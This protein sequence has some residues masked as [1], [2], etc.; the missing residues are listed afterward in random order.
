MRSRKKIVTT[1]I[2]SIA[3]L[4]SCTSTTIINGL[5]ETHTATEGIQGVDVKKYFNYQYFRPSSIQKLEQ[6][7]VNL[8]LPRDEAQNLK[9]LLG[10]LKKIMSK[11]KFILKINNSNTFS[12]ELIELVYKF[13]LPITIEWTD[14]NQNNIPQN[15]ISEIPSGFCSSIY[16]DALQAIN[17][18][19]SASSNSTMIV[20]TKPYGDVQKLFTT[21]FPEI[22][23]ILFNE[24]D[25][26]KFA[27]QALEISQ[28]HNRFKKITNLNPNQ[29]LEFASR[30]RD[31]I[32][33]IFLLLEPDQYKSVLPAF[34][35]HG[36]EKFQYIN[37]IS[38]LESLN[39]VKQL[40][41]FE[42]SLVPISIY[43]SKGIE[44]KEIVSL[45]QVIQKSMLN[46]WLLIE[47]MKQ[48]GIRSADIIGMTGTLEFERNNC[49]KR[50]LPIQRIN[51]TW[52]TS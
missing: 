21:Q 29:K 30:P 45:D 36:G 4:A 20:Y 11:E 48:A 33:K 31:D 5:D 27:S 52:V 47:I 16:Q 42:N 34:R 3:I 12:L 44:N 40:L 49:T 10:N 41:D 37:F 25:A 39:N 26:Q 2:T 38:A 15:L 8:N 43:L 32:K 35:Y 18:E 6:Y 51:S 22:K 24:G 19:I 28:S 13:D 7:M 23:S 1:L 14:L 9:K 46:D 17:K 50:N